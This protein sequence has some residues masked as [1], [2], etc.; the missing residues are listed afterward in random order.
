[1]EQSIFDIMWE[2]TPTITV[3]T[4]GL[5]VSG[6]IVYK[7]MRFVVRFEKTEAVVS[8]LQF[9]I[10]KVENRLDQIDVKMAIMD[11]KLD[12]LIEKVNLLTD[13]VLGKNKSK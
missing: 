11:T 10:T 12:M 8:D 5:I 7:I 9:R 2:N 4:L 13:I 1:M 3:F 6:L